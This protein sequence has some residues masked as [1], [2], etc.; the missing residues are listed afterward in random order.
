[1]SQ[2]DVRTV[3]RRFLME[4]ERGVP[5]AVVKTVAFFIS[6]GLWFLLSRNSS[7]TTCL[8][9]ARKRSRLGGK[10]IELWKEL[11]TFYGKWTD[12]SGRERR[13]LAHCRGDRTID[14]GLVR[15]ALGAGSNPTRVPEEELHEAGLR[16][17]EFNPFVFAGDTDIIQLFDRELL[18]S[19]GHPD[20]VMTNAGNRTWAVEFDIHALLLGFQGAKVAALVNDESAVRYG[21]GRSDYSITIITGNA[22]ESGMLLLQRILDRI[23]IRFG[24]RCAGDVSLPR[25]NLVSAPFLG[26]TMEL[27]EREDAIAVEIE[28]LVEEACAAK[29]TVIALACNTT[30]YFTPLIRRICSRHGVGFISMPEVVGG[31]LRGKGIGRA[32]LLGIPS[33]ADFSKG[34]SAYGTALQ[35]IEVVRVPADVL[36]QAA[37]IAYEVKREGATRKGL[38]KLRMHLGSLEADHIIVALT[39]L[40][41]LLALEKESER[42]R[43]GKVLVDPLQLYADAL[44]EGFIGPGIIV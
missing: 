12:K 25:I 24:S 22:P 19:F 26:M 20:T 36:T 44:A 11:K 35:D 27:G 42:A 40:S 3:A 6:R 37:A 29:P 38:Q 32:A 18:E 23:R 31:W 2:K 33:V 41:M 21:Y 13:F 5:L 4:G 17:G 16:F 7:A 9:A 28:R 15:K 34:F 43:A 10:G 1:M 30:H 8:D 14:L 39:E